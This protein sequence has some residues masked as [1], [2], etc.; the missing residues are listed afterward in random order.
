M[1]DEYSRFDEIDH[2]YDRETDDDYCEF[3]VDE[4]FDAGNSIRFSKVCSGDW[5]RPGTAFEHP[6]DGTPLVSCNSQYFHTN[7][8]N[9]PLIH[10]LL[11]AVPG[12][13]GYV[14]PLNCPQCGC[15]PGQNDVITLDQRE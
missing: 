14:T 1:P 8:C 9:F 13:D 4:D 2:D 10:L 7:Y 15:T 11:N 3:H 12:A 6:I 5:Y